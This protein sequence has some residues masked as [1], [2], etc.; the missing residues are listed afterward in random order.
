MTMLNRPT[1]RPGR[2]RWRARGTT[3]GLGQPHGR[4]ASRPA[5]GSRSPC[6]KAAGILGRCD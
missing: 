4:A 5:G 6:C 1:A 2:A 3:T